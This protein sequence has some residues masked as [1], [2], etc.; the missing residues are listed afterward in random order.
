MCANGPLAQTFRPNGPLAH[1]GP[2]RDVRAGQ[3]IHD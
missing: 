3:V 2:G 1:K